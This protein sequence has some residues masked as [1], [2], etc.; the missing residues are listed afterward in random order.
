ML[1]VTNENNSLQLNLQNKANIKRHADL[2][3]KAT[4]VAMKSANSVR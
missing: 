2:L 3:Q 4:D 1:S